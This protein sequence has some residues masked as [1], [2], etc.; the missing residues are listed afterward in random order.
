MIQVLCLIDSLGPG[1][2]Q[3][4]LV[5][6]ATFLKEQ[7]YDVGVVFYHDNHF[8]VNKLLTSRVPYVFLSKAEKS[9]SR[10]WQI[11]LHI[12]KL[13][14]DVVISYLETPS[15][16]A[17][18]I[19]LFN[20]RFR[21]IVSE[22]NTTQK[23]GF[24][25][26]LRF[27]LFR[28]ANF[29]VPNSFSQATY[30]TQ[31]F[32][33]V[34]NKVVTIPNYVDVDYF[35][36]LPQKERHKLQ[37]VIVV[38]TIWTSK[39]TVGFIDAVS[40][41]IKKGRQFHISWYG[42]DANHLDYYEQCQTRINNL[43]LN[44]YFELKEKVSSIKEEYQNADFFCLPSFYEGTPNVI[45]EAMA[46]GLPVACSSVCDNNRYVENG[47]NG[48]LF[49]PYDIESMA[50]AIDRLLALND[51]EYF[52]YCRES[53]ERAKKMFSKDLFVRLYIQLIEQ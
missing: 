50:T 11:A 14:P 31:A 6:L 25:E 4:Q 18:V 2:A 48:F 46:C 44:D 33:F 26:R 36:P 17:S 51:T 34:A 13:K 9:L 21:L 22:R 23:T 10:I 3:R 15:I 49:D 38:A 30:I 19:R 43:G 16:C 52:A 37:E 12:W 47:A 42:K 53:R 41:L 28:I 5:G 40:R 32:P 29:I 8:Y 24:Y 45:C 35:T 39:N 27:N 7:G 1:G 20:H